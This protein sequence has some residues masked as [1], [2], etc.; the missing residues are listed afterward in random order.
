MN[1]QQKYNYYKKLYNNLIGGTGSAEISNIIDAN[2]VNTVYRYFI[3]GV[4]LP[5]TVYIP[6]CDRYP[7]GIIKIITT[8]EIHDEIQSLATTVTLVNVSVSVH[9][10]DIPIPTVEAPHISVSE[11]NYIVSNLRDSEVSGILSGLHIV[12]ML[13]SD[14]QHPQLVEQIASHLT[15][16][17]NASTDI[18]MT[19]HYYN[20]DAGCTLFNKILWMTSMIVNNYKF[21]S[22]P[23]IT[24]VNTDIDRQIDNF[25]KDSSTTSLY[26][27]SEKPKSIDTLKRATHYALGL[28]EDKYDFNVTGF[29]A[30]AKLTTSEGYS[31][32]MDGITDLSQAPKLIKSDYD[33][34]KTTLKTLIRSLPLVDL[35]VFFKIV[36]YLI[37]KIYSH[38]ERQIDGNFVLSIYRILAHFAPIFRNFLEMAKDDR[39]QELITRTIFHFGICL[40]QCHTFNDKNGR[41]MRAI[42]NILLASFEYPKCLFLFDLQTL[43]RRIE[44]DYCYHH[45]S[46]NGISYES[47]DTYSRVNPDSI[48]IARLAEMLFLNYKFEHFLCSQYH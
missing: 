28:S 1:P 47:I 14:Q 38:Y 3:F 39:N 40:V 7:N 48:L 29:L 45:F 13:L 22:V 10:G 16:R 41:I 15:I 12:E 26:G 18:V 4:Y 35:R 19:A 6:K 32:K 24:R 25:K 20:N 37:L 43:F 42:I 11:H 9:I 2:Y 31:Q 33:H 36:S 46:T 30:L 5:S 34:Y 8:Q 44:W 23:T 17:R 27:C 21:V